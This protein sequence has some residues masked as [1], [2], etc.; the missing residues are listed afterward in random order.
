MRWTMYDM[1]I[2]ATCLRRYSG[3]SARCD[4]TFFLWVY[5]V[6]SNFSGSTCCLG[7]IHQVP[8]EAAE[9]S[10]EEISVESPQKEVLLG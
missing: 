2:N 8:G 5:I 10:P 1:L 3:S 7:A 9:A 4:R 6:M